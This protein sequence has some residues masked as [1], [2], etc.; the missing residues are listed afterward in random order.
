MSAA[1]A[2]APPLT[3]SVRALTRTLRD[4]AFANSPVPANLLRLLTAAR[5]GDCATVER[6]TRADGSLCRATLTTRSD[7]GDSR[8][9]AGP[10]RPGRPANWCELLLGP[11]MDI[12]DNHGGMGA[13]HVAAFAG[14]R[15][16]VT[17]L[18]AAGAPAT[19]G[20]Q[21]GATPLV[22]AAMND[23]TDVAETLLAS[24]RAGPPA[25]AAA[26]RVEW[27]LF[28]AAERRCL[29]LVQLLL[30]TDADLRYIHA[31]GTTA[32]HKAA[33]T[34][35][36]D[37]LRLVLN[38]VPREYLQA[39]DRAGRTPLNVA[40]DCNFP[41]AVRMLEAAASPAARPP[42]P[43]EVADTFDVLMLGGFPPS[44][45]ADVVLSVLE[46]EAHWKYPDSLLHAHR[47]VRF[48]ADAGRLQHVSGIPLVNIYRKA[49]WA[50]A[51]D[52]YWLGRCIVKDATERGF[53]TSDQREICNNALDA[54]DRIQAATAS[55][56]DLR[57]SLNAL[58]SAA[59]RS[60]AQAA[61]AET[62]EDALTVATA[63]LSMLPVVGGHLA[64]AA[65]AVPSVQR[66]FEA[67]RASRVSEAAPPLPQL[68]SAEADADAVTGA[69][70]NDGGGHEALGQLATALDT[71]G[72]SQDATTPSQ[73]A[74]IVA[75]ALL[76]LAPVVRAYF[77]A[78]TD[79]T[80]QRLATAT[81]TAVVSH[82]P[83]AFLLYPADA[84]AAREV[85]TTAG[86]A[87]LVGTANYTGR[88][89]ALERGFLVL[90]NLFAA[91]LRGHLAAGGGA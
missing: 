27:A 41:C 71:A 81:N 69:A 21:D 19:T 86:I 5:D 20:L 67:W 58:A 83:V 82:P 2:A 22:L 17:L 33:G 47:L 9:A 40:Q 48:L 44:H 77:V 25:D 8:E 50:I 68:R 54:T 6:L 66:I 91:H 16:V 32:L 26:Y 36:E 35:H 75:M 4:L 80:L 57:S 61:E 12:Y 79:G 84:S 24:L 38:A 31:D 73:A 13:L 14:H 45:A 56:V 53:I 39:E 3:M 49:C 64:T 34:R 63:L 7:Y 29:A 62:R 30:A 87:S 15:P 85:V 70:W 10:S 42:P 43:P 65:A 59:A 60:R 51:A 1:A 52:D 90:D 11:Q 72:S 18:L 78:S 55:V 46:V 89:E 76:A 23:H 88:R 37:V 74:T 28:V